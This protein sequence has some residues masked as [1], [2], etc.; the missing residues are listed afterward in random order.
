MKMPKSSKSLHKL[1]I[2]LGKMTNNQKSEGKINTNG[3][4]YYI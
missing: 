3:G 2:E 1:N 4:E